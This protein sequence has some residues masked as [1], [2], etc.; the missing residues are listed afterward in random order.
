MAGVAMAKTGRPGA[1]EAKARTD[2]ARALQ[3][4]GTLPGWY[5]SLPESIRRAMAQHLTF[6]AYAANETLYSQGE[7]PKGLYGIVSGQI[8]TI[9]SAQGG[10]ESLLS[11]LRDGEWTGFIGMLDGQPNSFS[12]T[13]AVPTVVAFLPLAAIEKIFGDRVDSLNLLLQP[14]LQVLRFALYFLIETNGRP[15]T[16]VVAQRLLDLARCI[17]TPGSPPV[18]TIDALSQEDIGTATYLTRPTV[19]RA[20]QELSAKGAISVGYGRVQIEDAALLDKLAQGLQG[21]EPD[22]PVPSVKDPVWS[23]D[24]PTIPPP[25][26]LDEALLSGGW[27]PSLPLELRAAVRDAMVFRQFLPGETVFASGEQSQGIYFMASGQGRLLGEAR[28]GGKMLVNMFQT[29]EWTAFSA[30]IINGPQ[31]LSLVATRKSVVGLLPMDAVHRLFFGHTAH[32]RHLMRPAL[33]LLR[34]LYR[35]LI[36]TNWRPPA[37]VV[38]TRLF[39][40]ARHPSQPELAPR[41]FLDSLRQDGVWKDPYP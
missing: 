41:K 10:Q 34:Y 19:N 3:R 4:L 8:K 14:M 16:R 28:D 1:K 29:G 40:M 31:L 25:Q 30:A 22:V 20:L 15:P 17:Y 27:S 18:P 23:K 35:Y 5:A 13:A 7:A 24:D 33:A 39:E 12:T 26:K 9:G 37:Q 6:R 36:E 38:A 11:I 21:L 2:P 32:Y